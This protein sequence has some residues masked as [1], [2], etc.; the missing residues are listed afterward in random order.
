[1]AHCLPRPLKHRA[2]SPPVLIAFLVYDFTDK[3]GFKRRVVAAPCHAVALAKE[4]RA[5]F[6]LLNKRHQIS[7]NL[8]P[9][10]HLRNLD[11]LIHGMRLS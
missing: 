7:I 9:E 6:C 1:M 2:S 3:T 4:D 10:L 5:R 8:N 11:I